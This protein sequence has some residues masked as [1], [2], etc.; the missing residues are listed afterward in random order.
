MPKYTRKVER[1]NLDHRV[2][3][4]TTGARLLV[5]GPLVLCLFCLRRFHRAKQ[6]WKPFGNLPAYSIF[7]SPI[8]IFGRFFPR[9]PWISAGADFSWRNVY[10]RQ[11]FP[12][13]SFLVVSRPIIDAFAT[14]KSDIVLLR[15][16]Y[17]SGNPQL[18][19]ADAT[20]TKVGH[21]STSI[22]L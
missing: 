5:L 3:M 7:V 11:H 15:S 2:M 6:A 4:M 18:L 22:S 10:K 20:A 14:S 19:L 17:P 21:T 12:R 9:I 1:T 8:G 13:F 16:L